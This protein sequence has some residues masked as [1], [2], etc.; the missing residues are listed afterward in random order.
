MK[1]PDYNKMRQILAESEA[2]GIDFRDLA[3]I[4]LFGT[5]GWKDCDDEE[6]FD[7]F[8]HLWGES[9]IPKVEVIK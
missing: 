3:D 4:F 2:D 8:V 9:K 1:K 5:K 7:E 6:V